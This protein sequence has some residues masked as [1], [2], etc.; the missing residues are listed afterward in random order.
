MKTGTRL[1]TGFAVVVFT[2][3]VIAASHSRTQRTIRKEVEA[4]ETDVV[5]GALA[6]TDMKGAVT[7]AQHALME[8]IY[9]GNEEDRQVVE[10]SLARLN[11]V[12]QR[13]LEHEAH[14][15][16]EEQAAAEELGA[17][18]G[19]FAG[20]AIGLMAA[21]EEGVDAD[22]LARI[23]R[24]QVHP[25]AAALLERVREH[26]AVHLEELAERE[27][28]V[29]RAFVAGDR[30]VALLTVCSVLLAVVVAWITTRSIVRPLRLL[31][32]GTDA[33]AQGNLDYKLD[34][35]RGDEIGQVGRS[36]N[37]MTMALR[38]TLVSK[39][40]L[41]SEMAERRKAL[42]AVQEGEERLQVILDTVQAGVM[43]VD[44]E[45]HEIVE[46]NP[47]ALEMF[48]APREEVV[49]HVCH[50]HV[51][52]AEVGQCPVTDLGEE[53]DNFE[54]VILT[55]DGRTVPV[56]KTVTPMTLNGRP[57]LLGSFVD[58]RDRKRAEQ[59]LRESE[60]RHRAITETAQDAIITAD[61]E[62]N[63][64]F[65]NRAAEKMFGYTA[66]EVIGKNMMDC[67]VPPKYH[68]AK[69]AGM[70]SFAQTGCGA[71]VGKTLELSA[72][73]KDGS[74]FPID[75]SVS[76][77]RDRD[78]YVAIALVRDI[79][80]RKQVEDELHLSNAMM[81][82]GLERE[83]RGAALLG[84][85][86]EEAKAATEAKSEFLANMSHEIRTP[87]TAILGFADVLLEHGNLDQAPPERIEA[88]KT[89]KR[90]GEYL[91]G[92]INDI[93]DLSKV[94]AGKMGVEHIACHPCRIVAEVASLVKVKADS[95]GLSFG[96]EYIGAIPETIHSDPTRL[97]QILIN[98]IGNAIKF[99]EVGG[100]RLV[101]RFVEHPDRPVMQL[102]VVDTG[103]GMTEEQVSGL[104]QPF[105]QADAT[106]TRQFGGTGLGLTISKRF[107]EM[108]G[109]D[110]VVVDSQ[111]GV[112]T[113]FRATVATGPLDGVKMLDDPMSATLVA[114]EGTAPKAAGGQPGLTGCRI[115]LAED[116]PDNQR[117]IAHVL[118]KAG[119]AVTVKENGKLAAE[120][121]LAARDQGD[122]FEVI[123]MDMQ[124]PVMDGYEATGLLRR[125][126]YAGPIIALTAHAMEDDRQK[127]IQA[128]CDDYATKPIDRAKLIEMIHKHLHTEPLL[129][130]T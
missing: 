32:E 64:R 91:L 44:A 7:E 112:G 76:G 88:A 13:H 94:E 128:G 66:D 63:I 42:R 3:F 114:T 1:T 40:A 12:G 120:A 25:V 51:C 92:I 8:Y 36:F 106:T 103:L 30:R 79:T 93:L 81:V 4:L 125:K 84:A 118:K 60:E 18:I 115:L 108:L 102:D 117:L 87:M 43:V 33:V 48:G 99:T 26:K 129:A 104:F 23:D 28:A 65:W 101:T 53:V 55:A 80:E 69:R 71:A 109:G 113:R 10:S 6:M 110:I 74:E 119:A 35:R 67:I 37:Q 111:E 9:H 70:A 73:R 86:M 75:I 130:N 2:V 77:Y 15:G 127:C 56:L 122:P 20:A 21:V 123:L 95:K 121:A 124:M 5:P 49:G 98:L 96:I 46:A 85:A 58:L 126:G 24:G 59:A 16:P 68:E 41:E 105:T 107:A 39:S 45:S 34:M 90:N 62:G 22:E 57:H 50:K 61:A 97:R 19:W 11:E 54:W 14:I 27:L 17:R 29:D 100:V 31:Q 116:G 38:K 82:D 89:I 83:K 52:P 72:L 78:G 47:A